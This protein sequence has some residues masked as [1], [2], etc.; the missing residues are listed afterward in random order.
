MLSFLRLLRRAACI[1]GF[2]A[3]AAGAAPH[4]VV[5]NADIY[6]ADPTQPRAQ[7][8]A[9]E[10]GSIVAVG[11]NEKIRALVGP[12]TRVVDAGGR[13]VTPGL[14]E[15]HAHVGWDLPTPALALPGDRFRGPSADQVLA[16]V[17]QA[18]RTQRDWISAWIGVIAARDKRNWREAL[19]MVAPSTPVLLRG[20]WGHTT[21][22]N[23]EALRRLSIP[24]DVADPL[25]GWWGRDAAGKL[26]GRVY[27]A[28]E[29]IEQRIAEPSAERMAPI[30][31]AA[32][33]RYAQWGV[34]SIHQMS[35]MMPLSMFVRPPVR[36]GF[37]P[38]P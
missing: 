6:T 34:T 36:C 11:R 22:V 10:A 21:I 27:E 26:N 25:G 20:F 37:W 32:A 8:L 23:S 35:S 13:L 14:I 16:A 15:S 9:I 3:N 12:G 7:A 4:L 31:A 24:E 2:V 30:F 28:A 38:G 18:A 1:G 17:E 19:D 29:D 33:Q 5:V